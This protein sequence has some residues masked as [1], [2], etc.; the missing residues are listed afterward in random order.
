MSPFV[1]FI[2]VLVLGAPIVS[3]A[4]VSPGGGDEA[5]GLLTRIWHVLRRVLLPRELRVMYELRSWITERRTPERR[6]RRA[7][8][9]RMDEIYQHAVYLSEGDASCAML[10]CAWATL[11]Y[12][13]FPARVP[14]IDLAVTVPVSTE[15][16]SRYERRMANLPGKLF[17]DTPRGLD[18][19][20]LPHFFGSAWLQLFTN[21]PGVVALAGELLEWSEAVFKLEGSRD[22]RDIAINRLGI[23]FAQALQR[24]RNTMPSD[25]LINGLEYHE[26]CSET[27]NPPR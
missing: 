16:V 17:P 26:Q 25:I 23:C 14:L 20:K 13:T 27:Q 21:T 15:S 4:A 3:P 18:R 5:P 19:D 1:V 7:E 24:Q 8:L 22:P 10:A 12:H 6:E 2:L 11:P 9:Q